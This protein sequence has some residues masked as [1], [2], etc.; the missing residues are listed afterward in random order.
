MKASFQMSQLTVICAN[1]SGLLF[2]LNLHG[3]TLH[4]L[5]RKDELT[6]SFCVRQGQ[7]HLA[8]KI[9]EQDGGKIESTI[10]ASGY[11][12]LKGFLRRPV[13]IFGCVLLM[14][15]TLFIPTRILFVSISGNER[16][17]QRQILALASECGVS[18]GVSR[19][20]IRSEKVKNRLLSALPELKWVGV[21]T[22]GCV[23]Q[24][25]VRERA[26]SETKT[27]EPMVSSLV[28]SCD[29]V[30]R[31]IT[32]RSGNPICRVGQAVKKGQL[33]VSGYA[34]CGRCI[35]G[36]RADAEIYAQTRRSLCLSALTEGYQKV[37]INRSRR[38][39]GL[40]IGKKRINFYKGSGIYDT[41]CVRMYVEYPLTLPGGFQLPVVLTVQEE[42]DYDI[43]PVESEVQ[44]LEPILDQFARA[45]LE[46][47]MIAGKVCQG[48]YQLT[49]TEGALHLA[50][51]YICD[52]MIGQ[53][54]SEEIVNNYE[55]TD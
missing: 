52:E 49:E 44:E 45:Y 1:M 32:V 16:I 2:R 7:Y 48:D 4:H 35:Y 30:I 24:I 17:P 37:D 54:R 31:E 13:L 6:A 51:Q 27:N 40:I 8:V 5:C 23:A 50:G 43:I 15:L 36:T 29:G 41:T 38:K 12:L 14:F 9:I 33:L 47:L 34:D 28:A 53:R 22:S 10:P 20:E 42:I 46:S 3:V 39:Y 11:L 55:Q 19:N 26:P 25:S 21:N 18:F